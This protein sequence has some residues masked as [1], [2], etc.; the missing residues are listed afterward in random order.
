MT[1]QEYWDI[2]K[3][4]GND[5][6]TEMN[7]LQHNSFENAA[8]R[9]LRAKFK[10]MNIDEDAVDMISDSISK[11]LKKYMESQHHHHIPKDK[12]LNLIK[13]MEMNKQL[14]AQIANFQNATIA[15]IA[16]SITANNWQKVPQKYLEALG[17]TK[18]ELTALAT[19][20]A[21]ASKVVSAKLD[22]IVSNPKQY[23][24]VLKTM[25]KY[26]QEAITKEQKE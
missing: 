26:A 25:S 24:Q 16:E 1:Q 17:F 22:S 5:G 19:N 21:N 13:F 7:M 20:G 18:A 14:K 15:N 4:S 11:N 23:E 6:A 2:I 8:N 12:M 9:I 3:M 10:K